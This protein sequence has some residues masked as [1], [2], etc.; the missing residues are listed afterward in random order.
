MCGTRMGHH[1][2]LQIFYQDSF[3]RSLGSPALVAGVSDMNNLHGAFHMKYM[4]ERE[5]EAK[6]ALA[7]ASGAS[8]ALPGKRGG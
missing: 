7:E 1:L 5:D 2:A 3:Q 8:K 4:P 6:L